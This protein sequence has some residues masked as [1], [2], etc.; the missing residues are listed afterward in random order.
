MSNSTLPLPQNILQGQVDVLGPGIAGLFIQ[1]LLTGLVLAQFCRWFSTPERND[2]AAFSALVVFVT[3]VG[4]CVL[5]NSNFFF[6]NHFVLTD[7]CCY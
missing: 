4:L 6:K 1:G 3:A 5:L 2:S 7:Y